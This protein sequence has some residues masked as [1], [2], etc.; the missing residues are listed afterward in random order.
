[1]KSSHKTSVTLLHEL[2]DSRF[3]CSAAENELLLFHSAARGCYDS[4]E[5]KGSRSQEICTEVREKVVYEINLSIFQAKRA[6][7]VQP[8]K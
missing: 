1:M 2:G 7:L 3:L 6:G 4:R 8:G 5:E